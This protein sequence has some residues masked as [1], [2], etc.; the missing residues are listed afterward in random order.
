MIDKINLLLVTF[1]GIGKIKFAPGTIASFIVT[2][3]F[4]FLI[5]KYPPLKMVMIKDD[6]NNKQVM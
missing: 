3:F 6:T 5:T 1:F 2:L 4:Y